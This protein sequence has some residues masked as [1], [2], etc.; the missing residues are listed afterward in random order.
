MKEPVN[1]ERLLALRIAY[2]S[3]AQENCEEYGRV[4]SVLTGI[5]GLADECSACLVRFQ[6]FTKTVTLL[7]I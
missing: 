4:C 3:K 5:L 2:Y 1:I 6:C 7:E